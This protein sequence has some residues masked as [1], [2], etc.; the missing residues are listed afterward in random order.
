MAFSIPLIG[1]SLDIDNHTKTTIIYISDQ[2]HSRWIAVHVNH[3]SSTSFIIPPSALDDLRSDFGE[4][5]FEHAA[6]LLH[7]Y[8]EGVFIGIVFDDVVVHVNQNPVRTDVL[9]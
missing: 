2:V 5:E 9:C 6:Q 7:G 4:G 8:L 3:Y 1:T